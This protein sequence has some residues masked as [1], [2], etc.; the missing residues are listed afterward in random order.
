MAGQLTLL[1]SLSRLR[2]HELHEIEGMY[3]MEAASAWDVLALA[4]PALAGR[5]RLLHVSHAF[6]TSYE[7]FGQLRLLTGLTELRLMN[8]PL[9][10]AAEVE[11][12]TAL[13]A[14]SMVAGGCRCAGM[15]LPSGRAAAAL[16]VA[17]VR[18]TH[19]L[20]RLSRLRMLKNG[21]WHDCG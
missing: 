18:I 21:G 2:V 11:V 12:S 14:A 16:G 4:L 6:W 10:T 7:P 3:G 17:Y 5:L 20:C 1:P 9:E 19:A 13:R 8:V 15:R